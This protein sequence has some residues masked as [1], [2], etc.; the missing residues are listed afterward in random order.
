MKLSEYYLL[1]NVQVKLSQENEHGS[2]DYTLLWSGRTYTRKDNRN[3][4]STTNIV[5]SN[6]K[7]NS[8]SIIY[9]D[10]FPREATPII[11]PRFYLHYLCWAFFPRTE[12]EAIAFNAFE[13]YVWSAERGRSG[14][15]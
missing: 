3:S 9:V 8:S 10:G 1:E 7:Q 5:H 15:I 4:I 14:G 11:S 6:A 2:M 13:Q 12:N